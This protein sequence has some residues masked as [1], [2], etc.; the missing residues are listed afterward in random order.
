MNLKYEVFIMYKTFVQFRTFMKLRHYIVQL[1]NTQW[2][3][4]DMTMK[5]L[6]VIEYYAVLLEEMIIPCILT[7]LL[8][9]LSKS[10]TAKRASH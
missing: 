4:S 6:T 1:L 3:I 10:L 9:P 2:Y 7:M 5:N 8:I